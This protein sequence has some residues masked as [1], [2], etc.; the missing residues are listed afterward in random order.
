MFEIL[1]L[2]QTQ[3]LAQIQITWYGSAYWDPILNP[4]RWPS[5]RDQRCRY[6]PA[7]PPEA[8]F[9]LLKAHLTQHHLEG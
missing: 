7:H 6:R 1:T 4:S 3:K 9:E 5:G 2:V 8:A